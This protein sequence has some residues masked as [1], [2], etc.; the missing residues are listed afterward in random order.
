M[1]KAYL[2]KECE[3]RYISTINMS[4]NSQQEIKMSS[5]KEKNVL[6]WELNLELAELAKEGG[7]IHTNRFIKVASK[8]LLE[9]DKKFQMS[10]LRGIYEFYITDNICNKNI[11]IEDLSSGERQLLYILASVA[12]TKNKPAILLMDEP[13]ISLHLSWQEKL[14]SS[15]KELNE[16]CQIIIVTHSPAIVMDGYMDTYIDMS[17]ITTESRNVRI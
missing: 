7:A 2:S 9:S 14:I 17:E 15:I 6:N 8:F 13:E 3:I 1:L 12:N 10:K 4:V 5:G 11:K 16:R